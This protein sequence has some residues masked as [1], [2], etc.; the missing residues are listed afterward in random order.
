MK[1]TV[2][3]QV[4]PK[5]WGIAQSVKRLRTERRQVNLGGGTVG[6]PVFEVELP[7]D[8]KREGP[9]LT[10]PQGV[11]LYYFPGDQYRIGY[12]ISELDEDPI[13]DRHFPKAHEKKAS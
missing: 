6:F 2:N 11:R 1:I 9:Y 7:A 4:F 3:G 5:V 10:T 13:R 8:T 12:L